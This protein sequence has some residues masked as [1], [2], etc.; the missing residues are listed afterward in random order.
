MAYLGMI[1]F[2]M[3]K[4]IK[5]DQKVS[6]RPLIIGDRDTWQLEKTHVFLVFSKNF[7]FRIDGYASVTRARLVPNVAAAA[8]RA[9]PGWYSS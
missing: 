9:G 7:G 8:P 2:K 1:G 3:F 5:K 6:Q 4:N